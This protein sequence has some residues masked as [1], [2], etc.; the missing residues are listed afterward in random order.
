MG[1]RITT[2]GIYIQEKGVFIAKRKE[3]GSIGGLWEFPGGKNRYGESIATTLQR[4]YF[5]EFKLEITYLENLFETT[6]SNKEMNY[7]LKVCRIDIDLE[8]QKIVLKE[9]VAFDWLTKKNLQKY[10]FADSDKLIVN[11]LIENAYI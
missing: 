4:E 5:E 1:E 6:F 9:H 2:A 8:S 11:F 10:T 3:G 7:I